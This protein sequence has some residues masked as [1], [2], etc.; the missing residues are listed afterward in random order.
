[1]IESWWT[2]TGIAFGT[3]DVGVWEHR[4]L[5]TGARLNSPEWEERCPYCRTKRPY[6]DPEQIAI[7]EKE[8]L[9][10]IKPPSTIM[11]IEVCSYCGGPVL[12]SIFRG[13]GYCS[14]D[15][16]KGRPHDTKPVGTVMT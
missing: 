16:R 1:M 15:C 10:E 11:N 13:T 4:C 9:M 14:V 7:V 8:Y 6:L 5:K 3:D 12:V 2:I